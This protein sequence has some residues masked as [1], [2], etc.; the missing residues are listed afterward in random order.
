MQ[1]TDGGGVRGLS[2]L[3]LLNAVMARAA[4]GKK[5]CEVFDMIGGTSTGGYIAI[6]LGRLRMTVDDC[7]QKYHDF[8]V[9]VFNKGFVE[10]RADF[11]VNG[12]FYDEG[13]LEGL[14]K[15]LVQEKT[16]DSEAKLLEEGGEPACKV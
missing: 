10:K 8:M 5:P 13:V 14:I 1:R 11:L 12:V 15:Q 16:G 4:P 9:Q 3:H 2:S 7:I 6:M